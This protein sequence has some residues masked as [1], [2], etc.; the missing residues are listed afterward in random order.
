MDRSLNLPR[1]LD[2]LPGTPITLFHP[3]ICKGL[4]VTTPTYSFIATAYELSA[5]T[6]TTNF[7][8]IRQEDSSAFGSKLIQ[9]PQTSFYPSTLKSTKFLLL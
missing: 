8:Q 2:R 6:E 7:N 4:G 1:C 3:N 9:D 5:T